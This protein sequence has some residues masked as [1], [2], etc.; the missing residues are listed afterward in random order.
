M[1]PK[2]NSQFR[3]EDFIYDLSWDKK[4]DN[5]F[6]D[7]LGLEARLRNFVWPAKTMKSLIAAKKAICRQYDQDF[8]YV[9]YIKKLTSLE[10]RFSTFKWMLGVDGFSYD[11]TTN[12]VTAPEKVWHYIFD[13]SHVRI[14]STN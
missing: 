9:Y 2:M 12:R 4:I 6:I 7:F 13:V 8:S 5:S 3:Q 10:E 1:A 14:L 11:P